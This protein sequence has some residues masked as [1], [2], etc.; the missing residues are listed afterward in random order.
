M[1]A[2]GKSPRQSSLCTRVV[3]LERLQSCMISRQFWL[4]KVSVKCDKQWLHLVKVC[5]CRNLSFNVCLCVSVGFCDAGNTPQNSKR[6]LWGPRDGGRRARGRTVGGVGHFG[7]LLAL[8]RHLILAQLVAVHAAVWAGQK[9]SQH[10]TAGIRL[11]LTS[12]KRLLLAFFEHRL[13]C[14]VQLKSLHDYC[15]ANK[16]FS[17][18][19]K[20]GKSCGSVCRL[21]VVV[22]FFFM[23]CKSSSHN[24][25]PSKTT[26][27]LPKI[28]SRYLLPTLCVPFLGIKVK[29]HSTVCGCFT[30]YTAIITFAFV[31]LFDDTP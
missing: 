2:E 3:F 10:V 24:M 23:C 14:R 11:R 15:Q 29:H 31:A 9:N 16:F 18:L 22:V 20:E 19:L 4:L 1:T 5:T 27:L 25:Q 8:K 13:L 6:T 21:F 12:T 26:L 7:V 17:D 30:L 28:T